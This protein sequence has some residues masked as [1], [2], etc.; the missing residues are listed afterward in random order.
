MCLSQRATVMELD[1]WDAAVTSHL[2]SVVVDRTM[3]VVTVASAL[4]ATTTTPPVSV[5]SL[6][7]IYVV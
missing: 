1:L 4:P 6:S 2:V 7:M 5:R 3:A